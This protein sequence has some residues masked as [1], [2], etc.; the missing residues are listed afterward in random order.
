MRDCARAHAQVLTDILEVLIP[1]IAIVAP[2]RL[3]EPIAAPFQEMT[4]LSAQ[5]KPIVL[6]A[7][8]SE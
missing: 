4:D 5:R 3:H 6:N 8:H 7:Y 1:D 2:E